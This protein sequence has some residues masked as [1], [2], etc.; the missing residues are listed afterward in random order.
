M[1]TAKM[2]STQRRSPMQHAGQQFQH[3]GQQFQQGYQHWSHQ[4]MFRQQEQMPGLCSCCSEGFDGDQPLVHCLRTWCSPCSTAVDINA[5]ANASNEDAT[6]CTFLWGCCPGW[7]GIHH[8]CSTTNKLRTR[9]GLE[10]SSACCNCCLMWMCPTLELARQHKFIRTKLQDQRWGQ[11][12]PGHVAPQRQLMAPVQNRP[13][14]P[15][16]LVSQGSVP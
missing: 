5:V 9:F 15:P 3:A 16:P 4:P 1:G 12:N 13:F 8:G 6:T 2:H 7:M 11:I 10:E 14:V